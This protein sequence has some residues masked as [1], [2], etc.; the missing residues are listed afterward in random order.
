MR[1]CALVVLLLA[2]SPAC[3]MEQDADSVGTAKFAVE[4]AYGQCQ[5]MIQRTLRINAQ[6]N[7]GGFLN[8]ERRVQFAGELSNV[9]DQ[10]AMRDHDAALQLVH[11][12]DARLATFF[13]G[14]QIPNEVQADVALLVS[15]IES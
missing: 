14:N 11:D 4:A 1:T 6:N 15:Q 9:F 2:S 5:I 8:Y 10:L 3:L 7:Y 13:M 12:L